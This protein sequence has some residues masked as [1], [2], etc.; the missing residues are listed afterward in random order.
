MEDSINASWE[1]REKERG[2]PDK[3]KLSVWR[4]RGLGLYQKIVELPKVA[5][6]A[7]R[8][9]FLFFVSISAVVLMSSL[10]YPNDDLADKFRAYQGAVSA[11][12]TALNKKNYG[13]AIKHFSDAIEVS[14]FEALLYFNRGIAFYKSEKM[15][16]AVEDFDKALIL[17][18][19][20][21]NALVYRGL[22]RE[23]LGKERAALEDYTRALQQQ[24]DNVS[25]QNNLAWLYA[26]AKEEGVRD[27]LKA[28]EHAS[29]AAA[30]SKEKNA[31]VLDTLARAYF[32]NGKVK[33]AM[34]TEKKAID[35]EPDN[36]EF[37]ENLALYERENK[38]Q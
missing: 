33:E 32:I 16:E 1:K 18:Q 9:Q 31:G 38:K 27:R 19:R 4:G 13:A 6:T 25:I 35:L 7:A 5:P 23:K 29:K 15:K 21:V 34:E 2:D 12:K 10:A 14:P 11:G 30:L 20:M 8:I 37:K 3:A 36:K 22:C 26:T 24:P 17:D 28:L